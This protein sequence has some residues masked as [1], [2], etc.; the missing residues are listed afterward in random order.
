MADRSDKPTGGTP[1]RCQW[2]HEP[3]GTRWLV[4]GC[5]ARMHDPDADSCDCPT[6]ADELATA[7]SE[8]D[9]ARRHYQGLREWTDSIITTVH[10]HPDGRQIMREAA[11]RVTG[12]NAATGS[13]NGRITKA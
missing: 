3:D 2:V 1:L 10:A 9:T 11:G 4:P 8:R 5:M 13:R 6:L 7:R 12:R